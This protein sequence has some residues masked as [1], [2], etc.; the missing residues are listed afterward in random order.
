[1]QWQGP[2]YTI[3][4]AI[5]GGVLFACVLVA[6]LAARR[7]GLPKVALFGRWLALVWVVTYGYPWLGEL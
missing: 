7:F 1:M 3:G 2:E 6:G 4:C 5:I